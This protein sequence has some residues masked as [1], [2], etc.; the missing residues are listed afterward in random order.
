M[1]ALAAL[2]RGTGAP[3]AAASERLWSAAR[4]AILAP[5]AEG[6][7]E[8][9]AALDALERWRER[10]AGCAPEARS[11]AFVAGCALRMAV[12]D[13]CVGRA[14]EVLACAPESMRPLLQPFD[15]ATQAEALALVRGGEHSW[16]AGAFDG[17]NRVAYAVSFVP[18]VE[19]VALDEAFLNKCAEF[20]ADCALRQR[21]RAALAAAPGGA[22][23]QEALGPDEERAPRAWMGRMMHNASDDLYA[24]AR[25]A[26]AW[27]HL[28]PA[29]ERRGV[30]APSAKLA[31]WDLERAGQVR[32]VDESASPLF[33]FLFDYAMRQALD[34]NF[35]ELFFASDY[36]SA[37]AIRKVE[38]F[39]QERLRNPPPLVVHSGPA[40]AWHVL[41][42]SPAGPELERVESHATCVGAVLAW[43]RYVMTVRQGKLFMGKRLDRLLGD[44]TTLPAPPPGALLAHTEAI[45]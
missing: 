25:E 44:I 10:A 6:A 9:A 14:D 33:L 8:V 4:A 5:P 34:V 3:D 26:Q 17:W 11:A 16:N 22:E 27:A 35:L 41:I 23:R 30:G 20:D 37:K 24:L 39:A 31:A 36:D 21:L 45:L 32:E 18:D 15:P 40:P 42:R 29:V 12:L 7:A 19:E 13:A 28:T 38:T 1:L 43:M 2:T